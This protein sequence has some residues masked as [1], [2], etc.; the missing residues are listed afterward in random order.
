MVRVLVFSHHSSCCAFSWYR[1]WGSSSSGWSISLSHCLWPWLATLILL[2][3]KGFEGRIPGVIISSTDEGRPI[4]S[5]SWLFLSSWRWFRA[6]KSLRLSACWRWSLSLWRRQGGDSEGRRRMR[7]RTR[8]LQLGFAVARTSL[9]QRKTESLAVQRECDCQSSKLLKLSY[10]WHLTHYCPPH[11]IDRI[12]NT[13]LPLCSSK[14]TSLTPSSILLLRLHCYN[15]TWK[16]SCIEANRLH[17]IEKVLKNTWKS[18]WKI[19]TRILRYQ[20]V[21]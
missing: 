11:S 6:S 16:H 9:R 8:W 1:N 21:W 2:R 4:A 12:D 13:H 14:T 20:K 15:V 19:W 7:G 3:A 17:P 10:A 18:T 5:T